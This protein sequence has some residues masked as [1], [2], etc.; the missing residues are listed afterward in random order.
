[1]YIMQSKLFTLLP[2]KNN[3]KHVI[4]MQL[5]KEAKSNL[6]PNSPELL[7]LKILQ[8]AYHRSLFWLPL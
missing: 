4:S 3:K 1:M 8:L 6:A 2:I 5:Q 7:L